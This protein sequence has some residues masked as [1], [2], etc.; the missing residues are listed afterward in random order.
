MLSKSSITNDSDSFFLQYFTV[1]ILN[2]TV[3]WVITTGV[4]PSTTLTW[5][6]LKQ[7]DIPPVEVDTARLETSH[8]DT[9]KELPGYSLQNCPSGNFLF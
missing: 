9:V 4:G 8:T 5:P 7:P 6:G 2:H 3:Q 1:F